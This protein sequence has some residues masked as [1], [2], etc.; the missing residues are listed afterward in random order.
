MVNIFSRD[1]FEQLSNQARGSFRKR[2]ILN[3]HNSYR[4]NFQRM[5]NALEP[6]TYI[7]PHRHLSARKDELLL[8]I[9]GNL[10]VLIFDDYGECI[11][12]IYIA[13]DKYKHNYGVE[14]NFDQWHTVI[15]LEPGCILFEGKSGPFESQKAKDFPTWCPMEKSK[16]A[17]DYLKIL[18]SYCDYK[19]L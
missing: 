12:I 9:R 8:A 14:I 1:L 4:E 19:T 13:S 15:A 18:R 11:E 6:A 7:P 2:K 16:S 10:A 3:I 5:F 17:N